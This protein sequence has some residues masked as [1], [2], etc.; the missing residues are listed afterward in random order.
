MRAIGFARMVQLLDV[1][2]FV[3]HIE[4][5]QGCRIGQ[6]VFGLGREILHR[7]NITLAF[8]DQP[9]IQVRQQLSTR[10]KAIRSDSLQL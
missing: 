10:S 6:H 2:W 7:S 9:D 5:G 3:R 4:C 1:I 8:A